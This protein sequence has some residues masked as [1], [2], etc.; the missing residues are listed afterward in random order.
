MLLED[1]LPKVEKNN[2]EPKVVEQDEKARAFQGVWGD[3][4]VSG[5]VF[6]GTT[7]FGI[8]CLLFNQAGQW[9]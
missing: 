5:D 6:V 7:C 9:I 8:A 3:W 1:H 4:G 2:P